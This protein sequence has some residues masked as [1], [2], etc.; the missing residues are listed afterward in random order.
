M[1]MEKSWNMKNWPKV[2][3]FCYQSWNFTNFAPELY[4]ICIFFA[5]NKKLSMD[6]ESTFLT[7]SAKSIREMVMENEEW[8]WKSYGKIFV[9]SV[10]TLQT[11]M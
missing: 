9:K 1:V 8:S 2:M 7:F 3:E 11:F 10:G 5:T 4:Q 6:V